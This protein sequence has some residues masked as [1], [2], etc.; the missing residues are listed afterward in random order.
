MAKCCMDKA[1]YL[2]QQHEMYPVRLQRSG[3]IRSGSVSRIIK[4]LIPTLDH[5][6]GVSLGHVL[7]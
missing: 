2:V 4:T 5:V 6:C 1:K 3:V 7:V